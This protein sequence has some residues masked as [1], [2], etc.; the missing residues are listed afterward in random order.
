MKR[1]DRQRLL[2][3]LGSIAGLM[4]GPNRPRHSPIDNISLMRF[5]FLR[6]PSPAEKTRN[7]PLYHGHE[8]SHH[9]GCW[10]SPTGRSSGHWT[11]PYW[12]ICPCLLEGMTCLS[13]PPLASATHIHQASSSSPLYSRATHIKHA[14]TNIMWT[15][16]QNT[17]ENQW[18]EVEKG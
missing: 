12:W 11:L 6:R 3:F 1:L 7:R 10:G 13:L 8:S 2:A 15:R 17:N 5:V 18:L 9:R 4:H 14:T 16:K